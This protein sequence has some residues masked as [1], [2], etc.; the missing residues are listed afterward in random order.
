[1]SNERFDNVWEAIEDTPEEAENMKLRS[2]LM[3]ALKG[4]ISRTGLG[5]SQAAMQR[6][7]PW[8]S[9]AIPR[10]KRVSMSGLVA[11]PVSN[12]MC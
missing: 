7:G 2:T 6:T 8:A 5:Q 1:M 9:C 11:R 4:H 10:C 3:R 12:S